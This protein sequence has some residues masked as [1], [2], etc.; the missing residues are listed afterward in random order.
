MRIVIEVNIT[1]SDDFEN[2]YYCLSFY[3]LTR[4]LSSAEPNFDSTPCMVDAEKTDRRIIANVLEIQNE[5]PSSI[6]TLITSAINL[7]NKANM[8][9]LLFVGPPVV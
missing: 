2:S 7:P 3:F 5:N 1:M 9:N 8:A 6:F 4:D